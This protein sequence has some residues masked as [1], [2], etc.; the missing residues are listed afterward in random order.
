MKERFDNAKRLNDAFWMHVYNA[1]GAPRAGI[2]AYLSA[3][4]MD[5]NVQSIPTKHVGGLDYLYA[6]VN[7]VSRHPAAGF[8]FLFWQDLWV[9]N[10]DMS[11]IV[12][13]DEDRKLLIAKALDP[14]YPSAIAYT[15]QPREDLE[16]QLVELKLMPEPSAISGLCSLCCDPT[17]SH[18][19]P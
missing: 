16:K 3:F 9:E 17:A 18:F 14:R 4:E 13:S 12:P 15:P 8:W 7:A 10:Q 5:E 6:R 19:R 11:H 1:F 2:E